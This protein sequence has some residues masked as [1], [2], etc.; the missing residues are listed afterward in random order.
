[1][2]EFLFKT[3]DSRDYEAEIKSLQ[4][5]IKNHD[6]H[7]YDL[8]RSNRLTVEGYDSRI[9]QLKAEHAI[10]LATVEANQENHTYEATKKLREENTRLSIENGNVKAENKVME[11]AFKNMGVDVKDMKSILE[12][13]VDGLVS[14]NTINVIRDGGVTKA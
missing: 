13:M 12:K 11:A 7:V 3:R 6:E 5:I 1:M 8:N 10:A 14:K 9:E 2:L 4:K